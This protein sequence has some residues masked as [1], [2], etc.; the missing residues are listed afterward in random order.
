M[1]VNYPTTLI[2]TRLQDVVTAIGAGGS[3]G[4][5]KLLDSVG[6][7]LSSM[8]LAQPCGTVSGGVLSFGGLSLIDPAASTS[9]TAAAARIEDSTGSTV[10]S[11]LTVGISSAFDIVLSPSAVIVAGQTIAITQ[12]TITGH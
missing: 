5:L 11:G 3:A 6:T 12:A 10:I 7:T 1:S 8:Q 4:L 2:N 9:G